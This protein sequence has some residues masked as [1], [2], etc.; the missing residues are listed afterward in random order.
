M[1]TASSISSGFKL[2]K[3]QAAE[4]YCKLAR[5][6]EGPSPVTENMLFSIFL[7]V[8]LATLGMWPLK[9][10]VSTSASLPS[11]R[12]VLTGIRDQLPS[13]NSIYRKDYFDA[14]M[15]GFALL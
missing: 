3:S 14:T 9:G 1:S 11:P 7:N 2:N 15:F 4:R 13:L 10:S 12:F 5:K 6:N 8:S